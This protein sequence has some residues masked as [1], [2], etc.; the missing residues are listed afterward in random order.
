MAEWTGTSINNS[1]YTG[2]LTVTEQSYSIEDNSSTVAYTLTLQ[3]QNGMYFQAWTLWWTVT[4]NGIQVQNASKKAYMDEPVDGIST[5]TVCT[6]TLVVP[7]DTDG[8][9]SISCSASMRTDTGVFHLPGNILISGGA[10]SLTAIPRP[11]TMDAPSLFTFGV[12]GAMTINSESAAFTHRVDY[13]FG[14]F[15]GTAVPATSALSVSWTPPTFLINEIPSSPSGVGLLRLYTFSGSTTVGYRDYPFTAQ[16]GAGV[17]PSCS[18]TVTDPTDCYSTFGAYVQTRSRMSIAINVS[19]AYG[20]PIRSYSVQVD[21]KTFNTQQVETGVLQLTGARQISATVTDERGQTSAVATLDYTCLEYAPPVVTLRAYRCTSD[22]TESPEGAFMSIALSASIS[23]LSG[24]NSATHAVTYRRST[25]ADWTVASAGAGTSYTSGV[26]S[27]NA[28]AVC[29][30]ET[31]VS[32]ALTTKASAATVPVS[33]V[34]M[35]FRSTG[36]GIAFGKVSTQDGFDCAM[37]ATFRGAVHLPTDVLYPVGSVYMSDAE[38]NPGTLF[39]GTW[40]Q[41]EDVNFTS[42]YV[43]KR[44]G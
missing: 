23:D 10:M 30:V 33:F 9:K 14:K 15:S 31:T 29:S 2:K 42:I 8:V 44:T 38:T 1:N 17:I 20:S 39:G 41:M 21:G 37:D 26:I 6:G 18:I 25:D 19:T 7:H 16:I 12:P 40:E 22:G 11:S 4:I 35:D 27:L 28:D 13:S 24:K 34:L 3:G 43:W 32:D 5:Y 36:K